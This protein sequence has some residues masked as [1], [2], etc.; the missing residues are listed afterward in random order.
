[1]AVQDDAANRA[2]F[3]VDDNLS[4]TLKSLWRCLKFVE[5]EQSEKIKTNFYTK[6]N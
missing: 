1:M 3:Y 5:F 6:Q 4:N 2:K